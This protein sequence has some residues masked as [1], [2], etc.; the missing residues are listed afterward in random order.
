MHC[1]TIRDVLLD[2]R[3]GFADVLDALQR[4][5]GVRTPQDARRE[6]DSEGVGRHPVRLLLQGNPT[7]YRTNSTDMNA[8][9]SDHKP[10]A[11]DDVQT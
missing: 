4:V 9:D 3:C 10:R 8:P 1:K 6:H 2:V 7:T 5:D 11:F